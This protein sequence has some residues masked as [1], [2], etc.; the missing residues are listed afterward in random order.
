MGEVVTPYN[1]DENIE[2]LFLSGI[3]CLVVA[4]VALCVWTI[5]PPAPRRPIDIKLPTVKKVGETAGKATGDL[6][7]GFFSGLWKSA[8]GK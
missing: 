8:R 7:K 2:R 3:F 6:T 5:P 1:D 4:F